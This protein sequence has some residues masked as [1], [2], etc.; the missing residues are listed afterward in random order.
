MN[1]GLSYFLEKSENKK[2]LIG[3]IAVI[4]AVAA[5]TISILVFLD[6]G[7]RKREEVSED[8]FAE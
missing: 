5:A 7:K 3:A 2:I 8:C 4:I 6:R 1:K